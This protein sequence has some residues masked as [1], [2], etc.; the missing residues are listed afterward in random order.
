T[1]S[2]R[3]S[4]PTQLTLAAGVAEVRAW[5]GEEVR[6][7]DERVSGSVSATY[8]GT[9]RLGSRRATA[10]LRAAWQ[11]AFDPLLDRTR[12]LATVAGSAEVPFSREFL[13][14]LSVAVSAPTDSEPASS[15]LDEMLAYVNV[16]FIYDLSQEWYL[17]FGARA[18]WSALHWQLP[19]EVHNSDYSAYV[20]IGFAATLG[21][22][23]T[24]PTRRVTPLR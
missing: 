2:L 17:G 22:T 21:P 18:T 13:G 20:T 24:T 7:E 5:P 12:A 8:S 1:H 14:G 16:P 6:P 23:S 10:D 9:F 3:V 19:F 11:P 15:E 4:D